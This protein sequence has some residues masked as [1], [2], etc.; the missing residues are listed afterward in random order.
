MTAIAKI[1]AEKELDELS[2]FANTNKPYKLG[3]GIFMLT[4]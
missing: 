4:S 3:I 2:T 1:A